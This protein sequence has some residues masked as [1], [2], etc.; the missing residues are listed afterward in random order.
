MKL[1]D[2]NVLSELMLS[3]PDPRVKRWADG[4]PRVAFCTAAVAAAELR[5]GVALM[6]AGERQ[7]RTSRKVE[8]VLKHLLGGRVLA[9]DARSSRRYAAFRA[10]R[11]RA[12]RPVSVQDAMIAATAMA[13]KV[14]AIVTRNSADFEDCDLLLINPWAA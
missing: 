10:A 7:K 1:L 11:Q 14:D 6:P 3:T 8:D 9:F 5:F 4:L 13:Y 2:T 12:G